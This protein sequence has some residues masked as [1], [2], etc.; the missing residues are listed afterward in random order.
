LS[1]CIAVTV[2]VPAGV[3]LE[4]VGKFI[5]VISFIAK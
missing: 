3:F 1:V 4:Q 5:S 2:P